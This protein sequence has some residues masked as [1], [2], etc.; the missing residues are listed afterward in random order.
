MEHGQGRAVSQQELW[1]VGGSEMCGYRRMWHRV[2]RAVMVPVLLGG[3]EVGA[4]R[5]LAKSS[6]FLV[7]SWQLP[8]CPRDPH[9]G[10]CT[11]AAPRCCY[12]AAWRGVESSFGALGGSPGV[13]LHCTRCPAR[14][15]VL[16]TEQALCRDGQQGR[17]MCVLSGL[18]PRA[19]GTR[20]SGGRRWM[21]L[22]WEA[23]TGCVGCWM[24]VWQSSDSRDTFLR[25]ELKSPARSES[26][27]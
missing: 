5:L 17:A 7:L 16:G 3:Q 14:V 2:G 24:E 22:L 10:C 9:S 21:Q 15:C 27:Q 25:P 12:R 23:Q 11:R 6:A 13:C 20:I 19:C 18:L 1:L 8:E 4:G 26:T